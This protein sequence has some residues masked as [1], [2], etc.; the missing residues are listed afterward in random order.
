MYCQHCG[1]QI[2]DNAVVCPHCG[3]QVREIKMELPERAVIA[4]LSVIFG[5]LGGVLGLVFGIIGLKTYRNATYRKYC[6]I[7]IVLS[8]ISIVA[9]VVFMIV[10]LIAFSA[11][12]DSTGY[13]LFLPL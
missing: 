5:A 10:W 4:Y 7:G 2:N 13:Y 1:S 6:K 11:E 12:V 9:F 8:I 3:C